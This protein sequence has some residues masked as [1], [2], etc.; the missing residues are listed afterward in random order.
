VGQ[1]IAVQLGDATEIK[2]REIGEKGKTSG[3]KK[4]GSYAT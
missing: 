2:G 1:S 4:D 3:E